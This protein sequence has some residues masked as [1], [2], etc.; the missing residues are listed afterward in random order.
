PPPGLAAGPPKTPPQTN[1]S[2]TNLNPVLVANLRPPAPD[3]PK[4]APPVVASKP[5]DL[6]V[7]P[8][9]QELVINPPQDIGVITPPVTPAPPLVEKPV[10]SV[11]TNRPPVLFDARKPEPKPDK[12]SLISRLNPFGG[13]PKPS[14]RDNPTAPVPEFA[15]TNPIFV[16]VNST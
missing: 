1:L 10:T 4:P 7:T 9:P 5:V 3:P 14:A 13:K 16:A 6:D 11:D 15:K 12:R 2:D 8:V